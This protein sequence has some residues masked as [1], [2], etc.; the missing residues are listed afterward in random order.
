MKSAIPHNII[1]L[2]LLIVMIPAVAQ[3]SLT[4]TSGTHIKIEGSTSLFI[5]GLVL[6]PS[7]PYDITGANSFSKSGT[8]EP[9]PSQSYIQRVH[10][11][12]SALP[13]FSGDLTIYYQDS[14]LAGLAETS[15]NLRLYNGVDWT[16]HNATSGDATRNFVVASG[17]ANVVFSQA[18]LG[19]QGGAL[20][21]T[22]TRFSGMV[23]NCKALLQ[24]TTASEHNSKHFEVQH[25]ADG[26]TYTT[27]GIV[28]ASGNSNTEKTYSYT[29]PLTNATD[30]FRLLMVDIDGSRKLSPIVTVRNSCLI[31]NM[32]AFPNPAKDV[33]TVSGLSGRNTL[34]LLDATGRQLTVRNTLNAVEQLYLA[35]FPSG[36]YVLQIIKDGVIL[37]SIKLIKQ[38][39]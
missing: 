20:P 16:S 11:L 6:K 36:N 9:P 3:H 38:S 37:K 32:T 13:A 5:D 27:V 22:L 2:L 31:G 21:V 10:R 34:R 25:S 8:A 39:Y 33:V 12:L 19:S 15:L 30:H 23:E 35:G 29:Y 17:L 14:E 1:L 4:V 18:T 7:G 24:W 28:P 26:I